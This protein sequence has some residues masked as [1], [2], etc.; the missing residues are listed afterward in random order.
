MWAMGDDE[1]ENIVM[2]DRDQ[3]ILSKAEEAGLKGLVDTTKNKHLCALMAIIEKY[4]H[5]TTIM[6][7]C[8]WDTLIFVWP[9][10]MPKRTMAMIWTTNLWKKNWNSWN[11]IPK[12]ISK[13]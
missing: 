12:S 7:R 8:F 2:N 3:T 5:T 10:E 6:K 11:H 9:K 1:T 13:N 4:R